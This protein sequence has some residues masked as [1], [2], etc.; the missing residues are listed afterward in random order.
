MS[1]ND[2]QNTGTLRS[3]QAFFHLRFI[4]Y[5]WVYVNFHNI[6]YHLFLSSFHT[7]WQKDA[8]KT[9]LILTELDNKV[10]WESKRYWAMPMPPPVLGLSLFTWFCLDTYSCSIYCVISSESIDN[11]LYLLYGV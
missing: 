7:V 10:M 1:Q 2:V 4:V 8:I 11:R 5:A 6:I 9:I 3:A